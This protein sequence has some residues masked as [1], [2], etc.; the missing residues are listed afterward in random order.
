MKKEITGRKDSFMDNLNAT[1]FEVQRWICKFD[2]VAFRYESRWGI[3]KLEKLCS[4]DLQEKWTRQID[5]INNAIQEKDL[6]TLPDLID[7]AI[8]GY[9]AL[10]KDALRLGHAPNRN[11]LYDVQ[12]P[13]TGNKYRFVMDN[14][15]AHESQES[16]VVVMTLTEVV[17]LIDAKH[18]AVYK[19]KQAFQG[20]EVIGVIDWDKGDDLPW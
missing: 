16:G 8:R 20:A 11:H 5:K 6:F 17:N 7:G 12:H 14:M 4:I 15:A 19:T 1:D 10:E 18:E 9:E 3:G 13:V 2:R